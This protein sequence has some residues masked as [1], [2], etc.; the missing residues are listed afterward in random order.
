MFFWV[1]VIT[2][3]IPAQIEFQVVL[4]KEKTKRGQCPAYPVDSSS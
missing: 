1:S 3:E 4:T 2:I